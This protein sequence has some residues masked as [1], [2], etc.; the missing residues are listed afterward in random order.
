MERRERGRFPPDVASAADDLW[1]CASRSVKSM[2]CANSARIGISNPVNG[3]C[4]ER[5]LRQ[6][7]VAQCGTHVLIPS[8][9]MMRC[10][11]KS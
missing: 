7:E 4:R 1:R 2:R 11:D 6:A 3:S 8:C 5:A 10:K 9:Q